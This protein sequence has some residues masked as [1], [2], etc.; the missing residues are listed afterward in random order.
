MAMLQTRLEL[1]LSKRAE[2]SEAELELIKYFVGEYNEW[3]RLK[4][5]QA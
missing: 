3:K 4:N 1:R 5:S 2:Y